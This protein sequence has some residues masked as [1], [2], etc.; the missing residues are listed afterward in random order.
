MTL[1]KLWIIVLVVLSVVSVGLNTLVL[2]SLTDNYFTQYLIED[3]NLHIDQI[4]EY[5]KKALENDEL[6][7]NQMRLEFESHLSDPIVSIELYN[8]SGELLVEVS[9]DYHMNNFMMS[10]MRSSQMQD[11]LMNQ[12]DTE[13]HQIKIESQGEVIGILNIYSYSLVQD[14]FVAVDFKSK[15]IKNSLYSSILA[16]TFAVVIGILIGSKLSRDLRKTAKMAT[17]IQLGNQIYNT[18][19]NLKEINEIRDSLVELETRIKLKKTSRKSLIDQLVHQTNTPLTILKTYI[20]SIR[21]GVLEPT[22]EEF[23]ICNTQVDNITD[24]ISNISMLI[25][26]EREIEPVKLEKFDIYKLLNQIVTALHPQFNK[27]EIKL[28]IKSDESIFIYS[29]KSKLSQVIYNLLTNA[30]KYTGSGGEVNLNYYQKKDR[31]IIEVVDNGI[32]IDE[33]EQQNIFDAY[34]RSDDVT[35]IK[36]EGIGLFI[37]RENLNKLNG[38]IIVNSQK[39][40]GTVFIISMPIKF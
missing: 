28:K 15:L 17:D 35:N 13:I 21:D 19:S 6:S 8:V 9:S 30:Y 16:I 25:D 1:K 10:G 11:R 29:D 24:F 18:H 32:G 38:D 27:K 3:Y 31:I 4:T 37:V 20:E 40:Y 7:Y 2:T 34:Y 14:S 39:G 5:T 12:S 36:G 22:N 23:E 33:S 26:A